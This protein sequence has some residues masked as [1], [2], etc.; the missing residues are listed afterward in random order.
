MKNNEYFDFK[1]ILIMSRT[2]SILY[3]LINDIKILLSLI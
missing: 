3:H 2:M 1:F